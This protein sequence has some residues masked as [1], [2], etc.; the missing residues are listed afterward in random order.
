MA[1]VP[2]QQDWSSEFPDKTGGCKVQGLRGLWT[3]GIKH[4]MPLETLGCDTPPCGLRLQE[5]EGEC[6]A[7][8]IVLAGLHLPPGEGRAPLPL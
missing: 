2:R 5:A 7:M 6:G 8:E 1:R 3:Q 4:Q